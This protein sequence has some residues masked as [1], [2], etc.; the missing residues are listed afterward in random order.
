MSPPFVNAPRSHPAWALPPRH[1]RH[2]GGP[3]RSVDTSAPASEAA[4]STVLLRCGLG[5][6]P[7]TAASALAFSSLATV[8]GSPLAD[9]NREAVATRFRVRC[10]VTSTPAPGAAGRAP[11]GEDRRLQAECLS[12]LSRT[13]ARRLGHGASATTRGRRG[14][15]RKGWPL[16]GRWETSGLAWH[17]WDIW[18]SWHCASWRTVRLP[19][20]LRRPSF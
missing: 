14:L 17:C 11:R 16:L 3:G 20:I 19:N 6:R 4:A 7:T 10:A 5:G 2:A 13:G 18:A 9:L 15:A 1:A 12:R 8:S